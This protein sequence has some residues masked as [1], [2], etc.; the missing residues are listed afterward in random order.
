MKSMG[1]LKTKVWSWVD[2]GLLKW[3]AL[4]FGMILGGYFPDFTRRYVW[5]I[6]VLA[7][8]LAIKPS[9]SYWG[10]NDTK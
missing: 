2:I 10:N 7:I 3:S 8:V 1:L 9:V 5:V 6:L 4:L